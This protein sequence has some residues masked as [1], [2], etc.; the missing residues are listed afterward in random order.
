MIYFIFISFG[1]MIAT[2]FTK[3]N[4]SKYNNYPSGYELKR[5]L[6]N[7]VI[8]EYDV[9]NINIESMEEYIFRDYVYYYEIISGYTREIALRKALDKYIHIFNL[10]KN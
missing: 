5:E 6:R 8:Y 10:S 7:L 3:E 2:F 4:C 1:A 9:L